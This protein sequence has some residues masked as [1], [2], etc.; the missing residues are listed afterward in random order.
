M[1]PAISAS[2]AILKAPEAI[3]GSIPL[4]EQLQIVNLPGLDLLVTPHDGYQSNNSPFQLLHAVVRSALSP[5]FDALSRNPQNSPHG[6]ANKD[7]DRR[8][9]IPAAKKKLAELELSLLQLQFNAEIPHV[10]LFIHPAIQAA[11]DLAREEGTKPGIDHI[12]SVVLL[13]TSFQNSLRSVV[14]TWVESVKGLT[15]TSRDPTRGTAS[16]AVSY[17]HLTLPTK[18]IV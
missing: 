3:N 7:T 12:P 15:A 14:R 6:L 18:R 9:G 4:R 11:L 8:I 2:V 5:Y 13:D 16:Q 17:T 1:S 10:S